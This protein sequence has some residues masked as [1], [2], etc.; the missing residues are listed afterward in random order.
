MRDYENIRNKKRRGKKT[1]PL[2]RGV[3]ILLRGLIQGLC[4]F[5]NP[6][7]FVP[8]LYNL[9]IVLG[10]NLRKIKKVVYN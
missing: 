6:D 5:C 9:L 7:S 1:S 4:L 8:P 2:R 3:E 10:M